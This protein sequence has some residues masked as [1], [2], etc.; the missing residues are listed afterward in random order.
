MSQKW[1]DAKYIAYFQAFT[2]TYAPV[3]ELERKYEEA[4]SCDGIDGIAIATRPDCIDDDIVELLDKLNKK[5][6]L[7][8]EFGFQTSNEATAELINRGY[9]NEVYLSAMKKLKEKNIETVTHIILG[10]PGETVEDMRNSV[11]FAANART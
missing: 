4:L 7:W 11:S 8:V 3:D 1:P 5:T 6:Y 10:L 2:N 9:K